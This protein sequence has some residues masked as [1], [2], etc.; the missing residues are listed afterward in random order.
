MLLTSEKGGTRLVSRHPDVWPQSAA[1]VREGLLT[2][3]KARW[4]CVST[5]GAFPLT[6]GA[7]DA[8][9]KQVRMQG[10]DSSN[11]RETVVLL[12]DSIEV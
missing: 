5:V 9:A 8:R 4:L 2:V 11:K 3:D 1:C 7:V 12:S 6:L 10:E